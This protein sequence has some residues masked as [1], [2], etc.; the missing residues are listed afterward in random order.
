VNDFIVTG[1]DEGGYRAKY[2]A[3]AEQYIRNEQLTPE[4]RQLFEQKLEQYTPPGAMLPAGPVGPSQSLPMKHEAEQEV[5]QQ[6]A[7]EVAPLRLAQPEIGNQDQNQAQLKLNPGAGFVPQQPKVPSFF[8][9]W[10]G[11]LRKAQDREISAA[12]AMVAPQQEAAHQ[13]AT[14]LDSYRLGEEAAA[15]AAAQRRQ[16]HQEAVK[17]EV[18][19]LKRLADDYQ[20]KSVD[21]DRVFK[22]KGAASR[23]GAVIS[24]ALG[25]IGQSLLGGRNVALDIIN[26][27]IERDI[28]AQRAEMHKLGER[29]NMQNNTIAQ[30]R[31]LG[32]DAD[33]ADDLARVTRY[34]A[35]ENKI[36]TIA[37]QSD[38]KQMQARAGAAIAQLQQ[39]QAKF[40]LAIEGRA[41]ARP[42][43]TMPA[44]SQQDKIANLR[45]AQGL[46]SSLTKDFSKQGWHAFVSRY[47]PGSDAN[48]Y[49]AKADAAARMIGEMEQTGVLTDA[50]AK[51]YRDMLPSAHTPQGRGEELLRGAMKR[52]QI[53]L[54]SH[55]E[56]M[57][58]SGVN[59]EGLEQITPQPVQSFQ[60]R[61]Q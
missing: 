12:E 5:I 29:V 38:D 9:P 55:M 7:S 26:S 53:K 43:T 24:V 15:D 1:K 17:A 13:I 11:K 36:K 35:V 22:E 31:A 39:E 25:S 14:D 2:G 23:V 46:L 52:L 6:A 44:A 51:F 16:Q 54:S 10:I 3:G 19:T 33:Q 21:P 60:P 32:A 49:D 34:Q 8:S 56:T 4:T 41:N 20:S 37:A 57:R 18:T 47:V 42:K 28:D 27:M 30:M 59:T 58:A 48:T 45:S 50:D 40:W 61:G